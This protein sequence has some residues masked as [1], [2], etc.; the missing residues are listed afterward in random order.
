VE[1]LKVGNMSKSAAG[2][3]EAPGRNVRGK[4]GLN[5]SILDQGWYEFKRQL[6]YKLTWNGGRLIAVSPHNT[7]RTCPVCGHVSAD[8]RKTQ[9]DFVCVMCGFNGNADH[10]GAINILFRGMEKLRDE[11]QDTVGAPAGRETAARI[12]CEVSG[13]R[14]RQQQEPTEAT[15]GGRP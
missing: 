14:G 2:T 12:A 10:I 15:Q 11:G 9:A 7:S 6:E 13:A 8:N 3:I 4:S 1:D 5:K